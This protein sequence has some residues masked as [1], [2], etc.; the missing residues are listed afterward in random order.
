MVESGVHK[1]FLQLLEKHNGE[2]G[3]VRLQHALLSALRNLAIPASNKALIL[4]AGALD[5]L[6]PMINSCT[7]TV[8]FKLLA[9]LRMLVDGQGTP[10][11]FIL[12]QYSFMCGFLHLPSFFLFIVVRPSG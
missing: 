8:A 11:S 1:D 12:L 5:I 2:E 10:V 3:D 4:K 6:T 9:T 7:L